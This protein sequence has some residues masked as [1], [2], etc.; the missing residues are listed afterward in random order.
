MGR[1]WAGS[2]WD[3]ARGGV[4]RVTRQGNRQQFAGCG[5]MGVEPLYS[6]AFGDTA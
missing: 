4:P 2:E 6:R 1:A 3:G 5:K